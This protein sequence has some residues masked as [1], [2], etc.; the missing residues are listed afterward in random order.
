MNKRGGKRHSVNITSWVHRNKIILGLY[1]VDQTDESCHCELL[2][3][4]KGIA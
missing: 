4:N 2:E 3:D 1:D